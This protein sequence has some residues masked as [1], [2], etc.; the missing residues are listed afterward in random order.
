MM[1]AGL[2]SQNLSIMMTDIQGYTN[3]SSS[4]SREEIVGLI[5]RHNQ[6][7][8]PVITFYGGTIVKSIGD[9]F[10]CTFT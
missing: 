10:L 7:M 8:I 1:P 6:L 3:A 5:R 4:S 9:A 2:K